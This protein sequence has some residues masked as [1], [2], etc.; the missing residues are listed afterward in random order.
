MFVQCPSGGPEGDRTLEPHGCEPCAL[1]AELQAQIGTF[2]AEKVAEFGFLKY[3]L[4]RKNQQI[5]QENREQ[6]IRS[7]VSRYGCEPNALPTELQAHVFQNCAVTRKALEAKVPRLF[8]VLVEISG[9]E[10]LTS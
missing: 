2:Y 6:E 9:I 10:P 3:A 8:S 5:E 4:F 7:D 1:P